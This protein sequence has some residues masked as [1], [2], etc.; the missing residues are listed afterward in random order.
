M[1]LSNIEPTE[2][3]EI[4][5]I[6]SVNKLAFL[7]RSEPSKIKEISNSAGKYYRPF[8]RQQIKRSGKIKWRH[9]DNPTGELKRIQQRINS[10]LLKDVSKSLPAGMVG[11]VK[12]KSIISNAF[13]HQKQEVVVT[14]DIKNCFPKTNHKQIFRIWR[15]YFKC[16]EEVSNLLTKLTTYQTRLPQGASTSLILCNLALLPL[17]K[18]IYKLCSRKKINFTLYVDDITISGNGDACREVIN[19][20]I[21]FIQ[22]RGYS[23]RKSKICVMSS[24]QQQRV[25]GLVVN[26]SVSTSSDYRESIRREIVNLSRKER[27]S[28][29]SLDTLWGKIQHIKNV[30]FEQGEKLENFSLLVLPHSP[31]YFESKTKE[32]TRE[33]KCTKRHKYE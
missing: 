14:L 4:F 33:C 5:P 23:V 12:G 26:K 13:P 31:N 25:T 30:S 24:S 28:N 19:P 17:Y 16:G 18:D 15:N 29:R 3:V 6:L 21:R 8:D 7:L 11:G 2:N 32:V 10:V 1:K 27:I 9:I 22:K 20:I